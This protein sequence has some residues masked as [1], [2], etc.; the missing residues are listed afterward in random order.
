MT[1][2]TVITVGAD[3]LQTMLDQ[4]MEKA[5]MAA[6]RKSGD[7]LGTKELAE[8]YGVSERTILN[9]EAAGQLPHRVGKR[10][11]KADVLKW[12]SDRRANSG[13]TNLRRVA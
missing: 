11:D 6:A 7:T 4:A 9:R 8:H 3:E 13:P 1:A 2:V 12:D 5:V 10:W